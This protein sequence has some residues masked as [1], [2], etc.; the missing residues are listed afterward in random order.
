MKNERHGHFRYKYGGEDSLALAMKNAGITMEELHEAYCGI[1]D[2]DVSLEWFRNAVLTPYIPC[3]FHVGL[4][5]ETMMEPWMDYEDPDRE[6][7][8]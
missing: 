5:V 1:Y 2:S 3:E 7:Q 8:T 6:A 4:R